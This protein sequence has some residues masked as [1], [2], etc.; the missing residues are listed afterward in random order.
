M[1]LMPCR[2]ICLR[3]TLNVLYGYGSTLQRL[4]A[5]CA[6]TARPLLEIYGS[7]RNSKGV[8]QSDDYYETGVSGYELVILVNFR[9]KPRYL[10]NTETAQDRTKVELY[11][12]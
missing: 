6:A 10:R 3:Q 1:K 12:Y 4:R 11:E 2:V 5:V 8:T 7:S 9:P